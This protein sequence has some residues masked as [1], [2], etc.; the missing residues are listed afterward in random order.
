MFLTGKKVFV[1]IW[2][3]LF[4]LIIFMIVYVSAQVKSIEKQVSLMD[5][6]IEVEKQNIKASKNEWAF[7]TSPERIAKL[8]EKVLPDLTKITAKNIVDLEEIPSSSKYINVKIT[9]EKEE[10]SVIKISN[11]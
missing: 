8:S 3:V 10:Y 6:K 9:G 7:L 5:T 4:F 1:T 2:G 11:E